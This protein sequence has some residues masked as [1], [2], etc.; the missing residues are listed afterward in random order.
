MP[1]DYLSPR[2]VFGGRS[3]GLREAALF[4]EKCLWVWRVWLNDLKRKKRN[5]YIVS[6]SLIFL[7]VL[8]LA[9]KS[10]QQTPFSDIR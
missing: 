4:N 7:F 10:R 5:T 9:I 1:I 8:S 3:R 6:I 2:K